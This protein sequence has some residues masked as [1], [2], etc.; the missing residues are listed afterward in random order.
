MQML[1][2]FPSFLRLRETTVSRREL[3]WDGENGGIIND[4]SMRSLEEL[5]NVSKILLAI[6]PVFIF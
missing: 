3:L 1:F 6:Y 4:L 2:K 5:R